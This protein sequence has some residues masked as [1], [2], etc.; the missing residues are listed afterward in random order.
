MNNI[1]KLDENGRKVLDITAFLKTLEQDSDGCVIAKIDHEKEFHKQ[2][3]RKLEETNTKLKNVGLDT[4]GDDEIDDTEVD[5]VLPEVP[6]T[7]IEKIMDLSTPLTERISHINEYM[8]ILEKKVIGDLSDEQKKNFTEAHREKITDNE[9]QNLSRVFTGN[10]HY[11]KIGSMEQ[12]LY[13]ICMSEECELPFT[14]KIFI[15][16]EGLDT[17]PKGFDAL[18]YLLGRIFEKNTSLPYSIKA[19]AVYHLMKSPEKIH[20]EKSRE[21]FEKVIT[22]TKI[23]DQI[24]YKSVLSLEDRN[25]F[26]KENTILHLLLVFLRNGKNSPVYRLLSAQYILRFSQDYN[27]EIENIILSFA[28][29]TTTEYNTRADASDFILKFGSKTAKDEAIAIIKELSYQGDNSRGRTIYSNQQNVHNKD[30]DESINKIIESLIENA[31][32]EYPMAI[33]EPPLTLQKIGEDLRPYIPESDVASCEAIELSI[34]RMEMDRSL[35]TKYNLSLMNIFFR[36]WRYISSSPHKDEMIKILILNLV[37]MSGTCSSGHLSNLVNSITGFGEFEIKISWEDQVIANFTGRLNAA[38][39]KIPEVWFKD[40]KKHRIVISTMIE[41]NGLRKQLTDKIFTQQTR[42]ETMNIKEGDRKMVEM[43][44]KDSIIDEYIKNMGDDYENKM[45][46]LLVDFQCN[47]LEDL[48]VASEKYGERACFL[49][50]FRE[51]MLEIRTE[52]I[53]EFEKHITPHQFDEYIQKAILRYE[54]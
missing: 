39:R 19:D 16:K 28:R 11:S 24:R 13:D 22:D 3:Q 41:K 43:V 15:A 8:K 35:Y 42:E 51:T 40:T 47:V 10:Y 31:Q 50:F 7:H 34:L 26:D 23:I 29:D 12:Y 2:Q 6:K 37:N 54:N 53:G 30:I 20:I 44:S 48:G 25:I 36:I 46:E 1:H 27:D 17:S 38:A 33:T 49:T 9:L 5:E 14:Q 4:M 18:S 21:Y 32:K 45:K 52:L